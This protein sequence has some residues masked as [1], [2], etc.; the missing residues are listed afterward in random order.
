MEH[1]LHQ[2]ILWYGFSQSKSGY[3][4]FTRGSSD[5][6]VAIL[7]Y[8]DDIIVAGPNSSI[9]SQVK[10]L[11]SSQFKINDSGVLRFFLGLETA[12]SDSGIVVSMRQYTLQLL[13]DFEFLDAKPVA[14]PM[15]PHI[16]LTTDTGTE[17]ADATQYR[18]L[19][20]KFLYLKITKPNIT[21][22][23]HHLSQF[24]VSSRDC[25]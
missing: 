24:L 10:L 4:L 19:I 15:N 2:S 13:E 9:I 18:R 23:V 20:A 11:L 12:C 5:S 1:H 22:S 17:L 6:F 14:T 21:F 3:P 16:I 7:L 25:H 8:V